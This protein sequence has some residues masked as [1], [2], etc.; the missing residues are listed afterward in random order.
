M[1]AEPVCFS[2]LHPVAASG[3]GEGA[4]VYSGCFQRRRLESPVE[5]NLLGL[6][7]YR[8]PETVRQWGPEKILGDAILQVHQAR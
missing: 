1:L 6:A 7:E 4:V 8:V 2:G 5:A 3:G